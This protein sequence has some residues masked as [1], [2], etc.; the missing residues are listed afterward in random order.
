MNLDSYTLKIT[1][2][3]ISLLINETSLY[4]KRKLQKTTASQNAENS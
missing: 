2:M 4:S 1:E 3:Q